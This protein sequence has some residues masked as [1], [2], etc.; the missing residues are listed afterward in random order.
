[1]LAASA[2][3]WWNDPRIDAKRFMIAYLK[4]PFNSPRREPLVK[5]LFEFADTTGNDAVMAR[6]LM[7]FDRLRGHAGRERPHRGGQV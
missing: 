6:F 1:M 4:L 7:G 5:R 3:I 2:E